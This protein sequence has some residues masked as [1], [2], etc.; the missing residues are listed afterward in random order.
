[1]RLKRLRD[2]PRRPSFESLV[3]PSFSSLRWSRGPRAHGFTGKLL[4]STLLGCV[5]SSVVPACSSSNGELG[6][7]RRQ[8]D[9]GAAPDDFVTGAA[10]AP[11][12]T[13]ELGPIDEHALLGLSPAHGPFRGGA[14]TVLRGNG[15][16]SNARVWFGDV[17]VASERISATRADRIQVEVPPGS[18]GDVAVTTQ[19]GD[20]PATRRVL[21]SGYHYDAF[22]ADPESGP[23]A[24]GN[25]LT[26]VGSG[27][28]W[29]S[30]TTVQIDGLACEVLAVRSEGSEQQLDCR[31]PA[32]TEGQK[33]ITVTTGG[34][35]ETLLGG[36]TYEPGT[37]LPGG[38]SGA[39][40]ASDFTVHVTAAGSPLPGA[41]V[42]LG[43]TFDLERLGQPGSNVRQTDPAGTAPFLGEVTGPVTVTIAARCF[44]PLTFVAVPVDTLRA[45]LSPVASPECADPQ[46]PNFGGS[47]S[48]PVT[49]AGELVWGG[50]LE[51]ARAGWVNVPAPEHPDEVRVAYVLQPSNDPDGV[52]RLPRAEAAVTQGSPGQAG[53]AFSLTTGAGSRTLYALAGVENRTV[54]PP[55]FTAYALGMLRGLYADPGET[56]DGLAIAMNLTLDQALTLQLEEPAPGA[57]GPDR[58][59]INA[60]VQTSE[61]GF[62]LLPNLARQT[63]LPGTGSLDLIGL[64][65]LGRALDGAEYAVTVRAVTGPGMGAPYTVLPLLT[66]REASQGLA[67]RSFVPVP[68]L[69]VGMTAAGRW[70]RTLSVSWTDRGRSVDLIHYAVSSGA[71]L[72]TWSVIA[73]PGVPAV[74]LP[75]LGRLPQGD[76]LPGALDV[77]VSLA[78]I[79]ELDYAQLELEQIRRAAW[80]AYAVDVAPTRYER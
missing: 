20:D 1:M 78:S 62:L 35:G 7:R 13:T 49:L 15:F 46:L 61:Q 68:T 16:A 57:R 25:T 45:A 70:A 64:P 55:R 43:N 39:P 42:I 23:A 71:G 60:A 59:V 2:R 40:I 31:L 48:R 73:P 41:Y 26:L 9:P 53:Y 75:E 77:V 74:E 67:V 69:S 38:L 3:L 51:F 28:S 37:P 54:D 30:E 56:I 10:P 18:P 44:Q 65:A 47:P 12:P 5:V 24:A 34:V 63:P 66:A 19:N 17:E 11:I 8:P 79:P 58:L 72:I 50:A 80:Q 33:S 14:I 76:L 29:T 27:T 22:Y 32:S 6:S 21:G 36:L 52:F 4:A